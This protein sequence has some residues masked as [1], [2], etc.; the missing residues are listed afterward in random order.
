MGQAMGSIGSMAGGGSM[1]GQLMGGMGGQGGGQGG[2][3][4]GGGGGMGMF[5]GSKVGRTAEDPNGIDTQN[6]MGMDIPDAFS[7]ISKGLM[8]AGKDQSNINEI[9]APAQPSVQAPQQD[10]GASNLAN[11]LANKLADIKQQT[12]NIGSKQYLS[13]DDVGMYQ[14][15]GLPKKNYGLS[16]SE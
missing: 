3:A 1:L 14:K 16:L 13:G 10:A 2:G 4:S 8:A 9:K 15:S 5:G 7:N 6:I 11:E 12:A